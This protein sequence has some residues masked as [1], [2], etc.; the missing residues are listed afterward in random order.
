[1]SIKQ[2]KAVWRARKG[3]SIRQVGALPYRRSGVGDVEFLLITSRET[4]RFLIPKGWPIRGLKDWDAAALEARQEAGVAGAVEPA[5]IG[6]YRYWKRMKSAFVPIEVVVYPL[7]VTEELA[8]WRERDQRAREWL[9]YEQ[10]RAIV[11]EPE[12]V[13]LMGLLAGR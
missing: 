4:R 9:G 6:S 10:A 12:L 5:P 3:R 11:D 1:M 13:T 2:K 8:D 7:L